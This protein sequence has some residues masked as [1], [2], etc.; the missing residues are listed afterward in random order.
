[1]G[2]KEGWRKKRVRCRGTRERGVR[3]GGV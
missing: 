2:R 3:G 1:V